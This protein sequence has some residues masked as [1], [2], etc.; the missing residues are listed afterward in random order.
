[1]RRKGRYC[2]ENYMK[3]DEIRIVKQYLSNHSI[4]QF[5]GRFWRMICP[6]R[7]SAMVLDCK[8]NYEDY[9]R[10]KRRYRSFILEHKKKD[11]VKE[12][13]VN[14]TIW[15]LWMQGEDKAPEIVKICWN[16]IRKNLPEY[17]LTILSEI[18]LSQYIEL[19]EYILKKYQDGKIGMAHFSDII[20]LGLL[21]KHGGFWV[22]STVYCSNSEIFQMIEQ[23]NLNLFAYR[24]MMRNNDA[25]AISNW[26]IYAKNNNQILS[27]LYTL[28]LY[29]W[30]QNDR[31]INYFI[32]HIFFTIVAE[33]YEEEWER[34]PKYSNINSHMLQSELFD[35]F[36][37]ERFSYLRGQ[38]SLHKLSYKAP[39]QNYSRE[40]TIYEYLKQEYYNFR[41]I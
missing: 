15:T 17:K 2:E 21:V 41:T 18:S 36:E 30:R 25:L 12:G 4:G 29:Y 39:V 13:V 38:T 6:D 26:F 7:A 10:L 11:C 34:V 16:S 9:F 3:N 23:K 37:F 27:C 1:M 14:K 28:L 35:E 32:F 24:N 20:R 19:P 31:A 5:L 22:D 33:E 40:R 8:I